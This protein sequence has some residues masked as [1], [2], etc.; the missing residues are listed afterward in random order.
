MSRTAGAVAAAAGAV[1]LCAY[2]V[3]S[4][5][6][7]NSPQGEQVQ[8]QRGKELARLRSMIAIEVPE[9]IMSCIVAHRGFHSTDDHSDVRPTENTLSAYEQAWASGVRLC[10]CDVAITADDQVV[11][12]HDENFERLALRVPGFDAERSSNTGL[13][14]FSQLVALP[15]LSGQRP[16]LLAEVLESARA[17]GSGSLLVIE[18]KQGNDA[19]PAALCRLFAARPELVAHVAIVMSF[20]A[21]IMHNIRSLF[22]SSLGHLASL[23][24]LLL[25]VLA[26]RGP[27]ESRVADLAR[28]GFKFFDVDTPP[29]TADWL[30]RATE[31]GESTRLDGL[32]IQYQPQMLSPAGLD[33]MRALSKAMT[34]GVWGF[35]D[36][37]PDNLYTAQKLI[38]DAGATF[39]NTDLPRDFAL[40]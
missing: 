15:L 12:C 32:Y 8:V 7:R 18:V 23:P 35:A 22:R 4:R 2:I 11:L 16:P 17:I 29:S 10:E 27:V 40:G 3:R 21:P 36:L 24:K 25:L 19:A 33:K 28:K 20:D 14:T 37:D 38:H 39:V 1:A 31:T 30:E 34:V 26:A 5:L 6:R 9:S 13:L